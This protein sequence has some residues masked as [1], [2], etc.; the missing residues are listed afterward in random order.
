MSRFEPERRQSRHA[1]RSASQATPAKDG[2]WIFEIDPSGPS[3]FQDPI[4][5][6]GSGYP[7]AHTALIGVAHFKVEEQSTE[8]L[9][10]IAYRAIESTCT[11]SAYG[12]GMPVQVAVVT[13]DGVEEM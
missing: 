12:V 5:S 7:L 1:S 6:T 11:S 8:G 10:A 4:A 13:K 3:Q 9:K 2:P